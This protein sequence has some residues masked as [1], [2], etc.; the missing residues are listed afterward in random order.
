MTWGGGGF[1]DIPNLTTWDG[2]ATGREWTNQGFLN[3]LW[4][5]SPVFHLYRSTFVVGPGWSNWAEMTPMKME[6]F[7]IKHGVN[8]WWLGSRTGTAS[9]IVDFT[10]EIASGSFNRANKIRITV[11]VPSGEQ[12]LFTGFV[13]DRTKTFDVGG[14]PKLNVQLIDH[15]GWTSQVGFPIQASGPQTTG[16]L[17]DRLLT[18][19]GAAVDLASDVAGINVA[20]GLSQ[21][22][23]VAAGSLIDKLNQYLRGELGM[24]YVDNSGGFQFLERNW[25]NPLG[26]PVA[27]IGSLD[28][29]NTTATWLDPSLADN[30][31]VFPEALASTHGPVNFTKWTQTFSGGGPASVVNST[32]AVGTRAWT[33][34]VENLVAGDVT[35]NL[36]VLSAVLGNNTVFLQDFDSHA[37]V[38]FGVEYSADS[39]DYA[40]VAVPG[41][42]IELSK[43]ALVH[44]GYRH[45]V[46]GHVMQVSHTWD[47]LQGWWCTLDLDLGLAEADFDA[48]A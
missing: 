36:N 16:W 40:A 3:D 42:F 34:T 12:H 39:M 23:S 32:I 21:N 2:S 37:T 14:Y 25:W 15:L 38:R 4:T 26:D 35:A 48:E 46:P 33:D 7:N 47:S 30:G 43:E 9:I 11:D 13:I 45:W 19:H 20:Q 10:A 17:I 18:Q 27:T 41:D 44:L 22:G 24:L 28:R 8:S 1:V 6:A 29:N 31:F 5:G